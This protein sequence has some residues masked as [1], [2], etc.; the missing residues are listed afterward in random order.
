MITRHQ[1]PKGLVKLTFALPD[2]GQPVSLVADLND[3][4][5]M[6]HPLKKRSNGTRSVAVTMAP[7]STLRFRYLDAEG[8]FFDDPDGQ[9]HEPNGY[10][11][12]HTVV[13]A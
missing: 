2:A 12:T 7:G 10:G 3:W 8:R 6:S 4:D 9:W 11:E 13:C 5:P 1:D